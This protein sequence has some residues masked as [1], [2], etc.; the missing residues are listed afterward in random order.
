M[1]QSVET[2]VNAL[3]LK[4][5][6]KEAVTELFEAGYFSLLAGRRLRGGGSQVEDLAS[7]LVVYTLEILDRWEPDNNFMK[8]IEGFVAKQAR[9]LAKKEQR[10]AITFQSVDQLSAGLDESDLDEVSVTKFFKEASG[11]SFG[12]AD[13][14]PAYQ[15]K[16]VC[17]L[18]PAPS[19]EDVVISLERERE[20]DELLER[21]YHD[22]VKGH[23]QATVIWKNIQEDEPKTLTELAQE[24]GVTQQ[25]VSQVLA[26]LRRKAKEFTCS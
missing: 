21:F 9:Y 13:K 10:R 19:A 20:Q 12:A 16:S 4:G 3:A 6:T 11:D 2:R 26:M 25:R 7:D 15:R 17:D 22:H 18:E 24:L 14:L 23:H 8:F 1:D 5:K